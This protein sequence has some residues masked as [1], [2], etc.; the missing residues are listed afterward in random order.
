MSQVTPLARW[1]RGRQPAPNAAPPLRLEISRR[2]ASGG[3]WSPPEAVA[4]GDESSAEEFLRALPLPREPVVLRVTATNAPEWLAGVVTGEWLLDEAVDS[5]PRRM[6]DHADVLRSRADRAYRSWPEFWE[7]CASGLPMLRVACEVGVPRWLVLRAAAACVERARLAS[8]DVADPRV[9]AA[10]A[11]VRRVAERMSSVRWLSLPIGPHRNAERRR[12]GAELYRE[13]ADGVRAARAALDAYHGSD[14]PPGRTVRNMLL[15]AAGR[16][17]MAV[18]RDTSAGGFEGA[19]RECL[20]AAADAAARQ[21]A[22]GPPDPWRLARA[23]ADF[24]DVAR[25][26]IGG[27]EFLRA[28]AARGRPW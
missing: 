11:G 12:H 25:A 8:P 9:P 26:E 2:A 14:E 16:L 20:E 19:I 21:R 1:L 17:G 15:V 28:V 3:E 24:A 27:V 5:S 13:I 4:F 22:D 18:A 10:L 7:H 6:P 23:W